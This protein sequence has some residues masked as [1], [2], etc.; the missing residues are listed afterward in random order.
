M[1]ST[2]SGQVASKTRHPFA[3]KL[4][5]AALTG[6]GILT[7]A[8]VWAQEVAPADGNPTVVT[9]T[10]VRK[11][12]QSAQAIKMKS[13]EV[14]DSIVAEEAGKFPDKNVAEILG[15]VPGVQIRREFGEANSVIIRGLP[16]LV[17]LLN[18]R[19]MYTSSGRSLYLAD[20]PTAM[21]QRVDAY[22][23]QGS[24]MVEGGTAGVIDVRTSRPFDF[25]DFSSNV[26]ARVENRDKSKTND[27]NLSGMVSNRW[28]TSY[29]E[30]GALVG[31]SYQDG[32]YH[33]EV[34]WNSPPAQ[35]ANGVSGPNDLGHVLYSGDRKRLAGNFAAQWRPNSEFELYAEGIS[36]EIR[37]DAQRQFFVANLGWNKNTSVSLIPG[38]NQAASI[39]SPNS[40]PFSLSS[41][42]AP[43]DYSIGTQGAVG[44]RWDAT[45]QLQITTELARTISNWKQDF[46]IMDFIASPPSVIG[47]TYVNGG[48]QF[49]YPG[50]DMENAGNYRVATLFDNH[51]HSEGRS[52]DWRAD[53]NYFPE[54]KGFFKELS[55][56]VRIAKRVASYVH[57]LNGYIPAPAGIMAN[58]VPGLACLSTPMAGDYGLKRWV[59]PCAGYL[60]DNLTA[61]RKLVNGTGA[62][63]ADDPLSYFN[64]EENT[65]AVYGKAKYGFDLAAIPFEGTLGMRVVRT[66][67]SLHG[68]SQTNGIIK[69]V[70]S[71]PTSTDVLPNFTLKAHLK[72]DLI[73]RFTAGKSIQR[74]DFGQFNPGVSYNVPST[75]VMAVGNGGNP[76]L[77]P[78]EGHNF[79][80]ALEWYFAPTGSLTA[81]VFRHDFKNYILTTS[82]KETYNGIVYDVYRPRNVANGQ[83]KGAELSYQQFYDKLPG[84]MSGFGMQANVTY[85]QGDLTDANGVSN[86]FVGMSK[87]SYN[88]VGLY[89]KNGLSA[90]L[91]Y[92]WRDK[93]VDAFNYRGL[94][95]DL[96]V[97]PIKT[98]DGSLSYKINEKLSVTMD[99]ENILDRAYHDYHGIETNPRD[100]RRYDRVV[101]VSLRWK[102]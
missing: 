74:P 22:K 82:S 75:T 60:L 6:A 87:M 17:T 16:G 40:Y 50:Y 70:I 47:N 3:L 76:D 92:S 7:G 72:S 98:L 33:D 42:Q 54:N 31:L 69:P 23:S 12:A 57:E 64:N 93:F 86:P 71:E 56:G 90:R 10:G 21:L 39:S 88:L 100:L 13:D 48:A 9:V 102:N 67:S 2:I 51:S 73:G 45:P 5:V 58:S 96:M 59:T 85:M 97:A 24:E 29:G 91:A 43:R 83:L 79:D 34:T 41:T 94:G 19:E 11:A 95:F 46:P 20:I 35:Q 68:N 80:A 18:G 36:T 1:K 77:K 62:A 78:I 101:G 14:L 53:A 66:S 28:K 37:H 81:T 52:T 38:T 30:I 49:Y 99:V 27:P 63:T 25:K 4:T 26:T 32:H 84:W 61:V 44:A 55:T 8:S 65:Y 15:R 89:E